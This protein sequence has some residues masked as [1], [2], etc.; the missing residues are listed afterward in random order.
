MF[1]KVI[2][3][4]GTIAVTIIVTYAAYFYISELIR[5]ISENS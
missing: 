4:V 5:I 2:N 1:D 3:T